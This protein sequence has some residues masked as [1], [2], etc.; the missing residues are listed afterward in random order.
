V[1]SN[2]FDKLAD[3]Y[4]AWYDSDEGSDIFSIE[5][6]CVQQLLHERRGRWLEVGVGTGRFAK[7][8]RIVDGLEPSVPMLRL[9]VPRG[10]RGVVGRGESLPYL[11]S[12]FDGVLLIVTICFLDDPVGALSECARV[13]RKDG[14][15]IV[16]M[17]P[18]D[19]QLGRAYQRKGREGHPFYAIAKF[20]SYGEVIQMAGRAGC[21]FDQAVSCLFGGP[22]ENGNRISGP[23][24]GLVP[25][26][27][28]V[29]LRFSLR[30]E[31]RLG[32]SARPAAHGEA[33]PA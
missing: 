19:S 20:Y 11:D 2:P 29:A 26:A 23:R 14:S 28:F 9:A 21:V 32:S 30:E 10:I 12:C 33:Q 24:S 3:R 5:V 1:Q 18:A 27:G 16:G 13:L 7:A 15:L 8:L 17:V 4:D 31:P 22:G 25:N 6:A